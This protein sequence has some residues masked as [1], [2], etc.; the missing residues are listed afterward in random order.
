MA[1]VCGPAGLRPCWAAAV[2][3]CGGGLTG[4]RLKTLTNLKNLKQ[5]NNIFGKRCRE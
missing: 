4:K 3:A 1:V 5:E 2:L